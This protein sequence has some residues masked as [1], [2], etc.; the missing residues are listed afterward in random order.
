MDLQKFLEIIRWRHL[1]VLFSYLITAI[2]LNI[3]NYNLEK[4]GLILIGALSAFFTVYMYNYVSDTQEDKQNKKA[5]PI[6]NGMSKKAITL[7]ATSAFI[8]AVLS[9][10]ILNIGALISISVFILIGILYSIR[11]LGIKK[12]FFVKNLSIGIAWFFLFL[13]MSLGF[14]SQI[15]VG[16][17]FI[18]FFIAI[19]SFIGSVVRDMVD[20]I[21][22][23]KAGVKTIPIVL[24]VDGTASLF[25]ILTIF[26]YTLLL[27]LIFAGF[28]NQLFLVLLITLP[29]RLLMVFYTYQ[30]N[31]KLVGTYSLASY[32]TTAILLLAIK[33][34]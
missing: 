26:Q 11:K 5:S 22:D 14:N 31:L 34:I 29:I 17:I 25:L 1:V 33:V 8:L 15:Q 32:V 19:L 30:H 12:V 21:G 27:V 18:A 28:L 23:S 10:G 4:T 7:I 6:T 24:K 13:F 3:E 9:A 20:V 16:T 2:A